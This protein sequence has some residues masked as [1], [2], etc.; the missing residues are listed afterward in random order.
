M[1]IITAEFL[2]EFLK[3]CN[4]NARVYIG[5]VQGTA[6]PIASISGD[7]PYEDIGNAS[8]VFIDTEASISAFM[9]GCMLGVFQQNVRITEP[10]PETDADTAPA[11]TECPPD[12][13]S[14]ILTNDDNERLDDFAD[15][16]NGLDN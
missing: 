13:D 5:G 2:L 12:N 11:D 1:A 15:F 7:V 10:Y 9:L 16:L 3:D 8:A 4:P 14:P 6:H